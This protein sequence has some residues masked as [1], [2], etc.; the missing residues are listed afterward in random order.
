MSS[1]AVIRQPGGA[2]AGQLWTLCSDACLVAF[3]RGGEPAEAEPAPEPAEPAGCRNCRDMRRLA[4]PG[5]CPIC[6]GLPHEQV[7]T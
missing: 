7:P 2:H 5:R 4:I 3:L 6:G 1:Y